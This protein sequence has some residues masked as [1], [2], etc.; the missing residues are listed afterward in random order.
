MAQRRFV[1]LQRLLTSYCE[2]A[3]TGCA[4]STCATASCST[5]QHNVPMLLRASPGRAT[6]RC[7]STQPPSGGGPSSSSS[8]SAGTGSRMSRLGSSIP[9]ARTAAEAAAAAKDPLA[10]T[11]AGSIPKGFFAARQDAFNAIPKTP[12]LL[13]FGGGWHPCYILSRS[14]GIGELRKWWQKE[15]TLQAPKPQQVAASAVPCCNV[16][17]EEVLTSARN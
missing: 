14:A 17:G 15:P 12:K 16:A 10:G 6:L 9:A 5:A 7:F 4:A 8:S 3:Q 11:I 1:A 2:V 13:G